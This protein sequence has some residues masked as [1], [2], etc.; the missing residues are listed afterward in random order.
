M[1]NER[2][3]IGNSGKNLLVYYPVSSISSVI[4]R[5]NERKNLHFS[6]IGSISA[7]AVSYVNPMPEGTGKNSAIS[8]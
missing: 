7:K 6:T 8:I 2:N 1:F 5:D 4:T 3:F